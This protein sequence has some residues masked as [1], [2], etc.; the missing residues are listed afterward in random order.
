LDLSERQ[1][2]R[3]G[4]PVSLTPKDFETLVLLV[5]RRGHVVEKDDLL[6]EVWKDSF[7]E[8]ANISRHVWTLRKTLGENENGQSYIETVPKRGYRFLAKAQEAGNGADQLVLERRS[9]VHITAE[10][11]DEPSARQREFAENL[12]QKLLTA[13]REK[14][15]WA[16]WRW[17][18]GVLSILVV[19]V[20]VMLYRNWVETRKGQAE[21]AATAM[22]RSIAVLPFVNASNNPEVEYLS[23]GMTESLI[24]N[25]SQLPHL[26]VKARSSVFRYKGRE[27][28]PQT[29]AAE[30]SVQAILNGRVLQRGDDLVLYLS[31]VDG[32]NGDQIWGEQYTRKLA[33]LI[34]LQ[35]EIARDVSQKLRVRLSGPDEQKIAKYYTANAEAYRLYLR[36]RFHQRKD[37]PQ[38]L[39]KAVEYF[40]QAIALDPNFAVCKNFFL[41]N[42]DCA[43]QFANRPFA[44]FKGSATMRSAHRNHHA[45]FANFQAAGAMDDADVGDV[46]FLMSLIA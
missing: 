38:D 44:G 24:N 6:K 20:G 35:S 27:I 33:D 7:V 9:I 37:M 23:D 30:L 39:R 17:G 22:P 42:R 32:R 5:S 10:E 41:P 19:V 8:E 3:D 45:G 28:E 21:V 1:L 26:S 12:E 14:Q 11:D 43:F 31:L 25:L 4:K 13:I 15:K 29:V 46:K 2:F 34:S 40:Q 36:G 18:L 16:G